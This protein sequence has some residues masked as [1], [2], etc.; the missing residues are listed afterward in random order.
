MHGIQKRLCRIL[1]AVQRDEALLAVVAADKHA[2]VLLDILRAQLQTQRNALH[3]IFRKFPAGALLGLVDLHTQTGGLQAGGNLP[4]LV[5]HALLVHGNG[6]YNDLNRRDLRRK[7]KPAVVAVGHNDAA[8]QARR[9]APGGLERERL[10][11]VL[12]RK[13][14]IERFGKAV[15]EVMRRSCLQGLAVMHH[16]LNGIGCFGA[17][18]LFLFGLLTAGYGHGKHIFAEIRI[19]IE[20]TLRFLARLPG[21]GVHGVTLL[22]QEL[23]VAQEGAAGLFPAQHAA[24]LVVHLGQVAPGM[25]DVMKML[26][27]ERLR[28][29]T[30]AV[31]LLELLAAAHG[32]P[33]ALRRKAF[34][35]ILLLLEQGFGNQHWHIDVLRTGFLEFRVHDSLDILPDCIAVGAVNEHALNGRIVDQLRLFAHVRVPLGKVNLHIG[36]LFDFFLFCHFLSTFQAYF[37]SILFY[38]ACQVPA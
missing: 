9:N 4:G 19:E 16:A 3:L 27:E 23:A 34:D 25:N 11:V 32:D 17:V 30:D 29:G 14:D 26:T 22:P 37:T 28:G 6:D 12:I 15:A 1:Q 31:T 20:H 2:L 13:V 38:H 21:G 36:N 10:P 33:C 5:Q 35:M 24:P 18:E 7:D 8:D